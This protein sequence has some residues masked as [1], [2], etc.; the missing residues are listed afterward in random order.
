MLSS[1][2]QK[3]NQPHIITREAKFATIGFPPQL[4]TRCGGWLNAA[5]C[6]AKN[7]LEVKV[8]VERFHR[9]GIVVTLAATQ[10]NT[11]SEAVSKRL[12]KIT[13]LTMWRVK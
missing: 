9:F 6:H 8:I 4:V 5:L 3:S 13:N 11:S 1:K 12:V 7:L 2:S 10:I